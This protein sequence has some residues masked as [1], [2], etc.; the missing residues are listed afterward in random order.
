LRST[1][2]RRKWEITPEMDEATIWLAEVATAT[3]GG[4]PEKNRSGV[5]RNPPPTP[6]IPDSTPTSPP[7]PNSRKAF[8]LTSAIGR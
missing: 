4:M 1:V 3:T 6:N 8:T 5:I 7:M 2:R